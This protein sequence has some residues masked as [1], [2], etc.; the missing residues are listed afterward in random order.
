MIHPILAVIAFGGLIYSFSSVCPPATRVH[1][2]LCY[3]AM[4]YLAWV[5]PWPAWVIFVA[6]FAGDMLIRVPVR[7]YQ[8]AKLR[9]L[10]EAP[11]IAR[12]PMPVQCPSRPLQ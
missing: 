5:C 2:R 9:R 11:G 7:I 8:D 10:V 12:S 1:Q 3:G 4:L 6:C